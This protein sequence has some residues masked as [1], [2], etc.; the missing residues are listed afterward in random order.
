[1]LEQHLL[2]K[3]GSPAIVHVAFSFSPVAHDAFIKPPTVLEQVVAHV[4]GAQQICVIPPDAFG[5][6][7]ISPRGDPDEQLRGTHELA[8]HVAPGSQEPPT[9]AH[10]GPLV[11]GTDDAAS[12]QQIFPYLQVAETE[13]FPATHENPSVQDPPAALQPDPSGIQHACVVE[14]IGSVGQ[15]FVSP[16]KKSDPDAPVNPFP[17]TVAQVPVIFR[18]FTCDPGAANAVPGHNKTAA[19]KATIP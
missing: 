16:G 18:Q 10:D 7:V 2:F 6:D 5:Q 19:R 12:A 11:E 17:Q 13:T 4:G 14:V 1:M 3:S 9:L 15:S 8:V